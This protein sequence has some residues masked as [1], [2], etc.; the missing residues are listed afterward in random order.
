MIREKTVTCV[1][2]PRNSYH[3]RAFEERDQGLDQYPRRVTTKRQFV[4]FY[5]VSTDTQSPAVLIIKML[6]KYG[7][8]ELQTARDWYPRGYFRILECMVN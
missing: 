6:F 8:Y 2:G 4:S 5:L 7:F 1:I 3:D